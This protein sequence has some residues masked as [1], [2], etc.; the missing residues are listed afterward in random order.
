MVPESEAELVSNIKLCFMGEGEKLAI[1]IPTGW[2]LFWR[3]APLSGEKA[4][5]QM[6]QSLCCPPLFA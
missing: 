2:P 1:P 3:C 5:D 6:P 4:G